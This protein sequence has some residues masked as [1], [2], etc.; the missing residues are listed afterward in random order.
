M[1]SIYNVHIWGTIFLSWPFLRDCFVYTNWDLMPGL[2]ITV[3]VL[4]I[5]GTI[6]LLY[7]EVAIFEGLFCIHKLGPDSWPLYHSWCFSGVAMH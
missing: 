6:F 4:H 2:Y 3:G 5:W 7:T 1:E